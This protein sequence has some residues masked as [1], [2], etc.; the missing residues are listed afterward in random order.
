[1][2][3]A[4]FSALSKSSAIL[5]FHW[6]YF[7]LFLSTHE[8]ITNKFACL[9]RDTIF[10]EY[11]RVVVTVSLGVQL[12]ALY[13][14]VTISNKS[15]HSSLKL[16]FENL[17]EELCNHQVDETFVGPTSPAFESVPDKIVYRSTEKLWTTCIESSKREGRI[18]HE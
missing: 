2:K 10:L 8:D 17:Y 7:N 4:G 6:D 12:I 11:I 14:A 16:F 1:M 5:S 18:S 15:T 13:H 9:V 3:D